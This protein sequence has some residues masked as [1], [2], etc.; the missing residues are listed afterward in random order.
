[1]RTVQPDEKPTHLSPDPSYPAPPSC[2][3]QTSAQAAPPSTQR[4]TGCICTLFTSPAPTA[5]PPPP[6]RVAMGPLEYLPHLPVLT[7]TFRPLLH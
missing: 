2:P 6:Q 1:M 7:S 3:Y 5:L 4:S